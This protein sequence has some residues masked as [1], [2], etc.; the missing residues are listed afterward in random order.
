MSFTKI[1][2]FSD[3]VTFF[4]ELRLP[5]KATPVGYAALIDKYDLSIP[6]P[7]RLSAISKRHKV[8]EQD[9]WAIYTPRHKPDTTL[10]GHLI[11]AMKYE[12]VN[13]LILKKLFEKAEK[14]EI[15]QFV[16]EKPTSSYARRIWFLYE[17][18][19]EQSLEIPDA[20][21][22]SYVSVID[23]K[24]Q[25]AIKGQT[26]QRHRVYNNLPGTRD[27]CPLV[28]KTEKIESF[29]KKGLQQE[30]QRAIGKVSSDILARTAA[31]L[32]LKD[33]KSSYAIEGESPPQSRIQR[34]GRAIGE[35]GK[36][37]LTLD[38]LLRLQRIV[39]GDDRFIELG[40]RKEGG[41]IGIHDRD[42][43][44]PIPD[45]ISAKY[46]D[47]PNLMSG[48]IK[49]EE[50]IAKELDPV[51][52]AAAL[53]FGFV[54]IHPFEDGNG[55][56]HRYLIHHALSSQEFNP[57]GVVF[58]VSAAI[59]EKIELYRG[60]LEDYS[61]KILPFI[62][63]TPTEKMNVEVLNDTG[64]FYRYFDA[65]NCVE[66]LYECVEKTIRNDL[67]KEID[68]LKKYDLFKQRIGDFLEMPSSM[69]DLLFK[70]I[71]QSHGQLSKR[72]LDKEFSALTKDEVKRIEEIYKEVMNTSE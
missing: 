26:S 62:D 22:G 9:S 36:N 56:L 28:F 15:I 23:E 65:T 3:E 50:S 63:W 60:V 5:E 13:L 53:S 18:L 72:G 48:L 4:H 35:A 12:G 20:R 41:F 11:F 42:S 32:L 33:S 25:Y 66:F 59:L 7:N 24:H 51:M 29:I 21:S 27:F 47:L 52:S 70:F 64:D 54:Y 6:L 17:W 67:P 16:Q 49:F 10:V 14:R 43:R 61:K 39:I 2:Q 19:L 55:R 31:F 8:Y 34:W 40:L 57:L 46:Q 69:I 44:T 1:K 45:H 37:P 38:E 58:P 71:N 30:A 68:F